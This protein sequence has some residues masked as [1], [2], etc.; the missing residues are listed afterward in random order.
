MYTYSGEYRVYLYQCAHAHMDSQWLFEKEKKKN[1]IRDWRSTYGV[2]HGIDLISLLL[3]VCARVCEWEAKC[4]LRPPFT[5]SRKRW[6]AQSRNNTALLTLWLLVFVL[7]LMLNVVLLLLPLFVCMHVCDGRLSAFY[8]SDSYNKHSHTHTC[9]LSVV[10]STRTPLLF[11][12]LEL[13]L[14]LLL[15][16]VLLKPI[17]FAHNQLSWVFLHRHHLAYKRNGS[18]FRKLIDFQRLNLISAPLFFAIDCDVYMNVEEKKKLQT[19]THSAI[20]V[21]IHYFWP[22]KS[23][24]TMFVFIL[25]WL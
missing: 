12:W 18:R 16:L 20:C 6:V 14:L 7:L 25:Q 22:L 10:P 23:A 1:H 3:F 17:G 9:T 8:F 15:S 19:H 5:Q 2:Q 11:R 13:L 24:C 4:L 21:R